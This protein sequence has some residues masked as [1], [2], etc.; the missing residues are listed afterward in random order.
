MSASVSPLPSSE[1]NSSHSSEGSSVSGFVVV[2]K[3]DGQLLNSDDSKIGKI[4]EIPGKSESLPQGG[5]VSQN[6]H[7]LA[8]R[9]QNLSKEN[10]QLKGVL[11]QNNELL[12]VGFISNVNISWNYVKP[13]NTFTFWSQL[14]KYLLAQS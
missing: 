1:M 10:E 7:E 2:S 8:D 13:E 14:N 4:A 11:L 9:V 6:E 3:D 12:E 5:S